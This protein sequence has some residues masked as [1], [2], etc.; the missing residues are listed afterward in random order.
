MTA[1]PIPYTAPDQ[2]VQPN[3]LRSYLTDQIE[4]ILDGLVGLREGSDP[5]HD[6]RVAI[7][8]VRSTLRVFGAELDQDAA[9]ALERD[10]KWFAAVLGDVRDAQVQRR[11]LQAA[12]NELPD[13]V[14]LGPVSARIKRDLRADEA[15]A[16]TGWPKRWTLLAIWT[17]SP[18]CN[19]GAQTRRCTAI[20]TGRGCGTRH[21]RPVTKQTGDS[22]RRW[23]RVTTHCC[24]VPARPP[25]V[26]GTPQN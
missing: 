23:T 12:L 15:P 19:A 21:V 11:R 4:R 13:D 17:W 14:V 5:I 7:R 1:P 3:A 9:A 20:S 26:P 18:S 8:R 24:T 6:T 22:P 16:R 25:N 2:A 10:L